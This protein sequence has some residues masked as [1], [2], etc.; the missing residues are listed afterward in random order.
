M[1]E[2]YNLWPAAS[3]T[4]RDKQLSFISNQEL[5]SNIKTLT[6]ATMKL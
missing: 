6:G 3:K 4:S 5:A 2:V 1:E